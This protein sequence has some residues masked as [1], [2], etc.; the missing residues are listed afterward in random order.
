MK[1]K[2]TCYFI[3]NILTDFFLAFRPYLVGSLRLNTD[4][5]LRVYPDSA[6]QTIYVPNIE[7]EL[8]ALEAN[9]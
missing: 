9:N 2:I 1:E 7:P 4:T 3:N 8:S 5:V 6:E